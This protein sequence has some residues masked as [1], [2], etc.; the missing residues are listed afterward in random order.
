MN[1]W[2]EGVLDKA[3]SENDGC[4]C[5][6]G[7]GQEEMEQCFGAQNVNKDSDESWKT[8]SAGAN[9]GYRADS[10]HLEVLPGC[11][12]IQNGPA[13]ATPASGAGCTAAP[14]APASGNNSKASSAAASQ[15]PAASASSAAD[16]KTTAKASA[17]V[18]PEAVSS[19]PE[20]TAPSSLYPSYAAGLPNKGIEKETGDYDA[21]KPT[22]A[23]PSG[24]GYPTGP[25]VP[26]GQ[27]P[28]PVAPGSDE[29]CKAP[30]TVTYTPTVT[31]TASAANVADASTCA[32]ET[33]V[34]K[35]L[36]E[37]VT[38]QPSGAKPTSSSS[39]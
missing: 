18:T 26:A 31:V 35:T 27:T 21:A 1:G 29:D 34:Y 33:T 37:T 7:C 6:C 17:T 20:S 16:Y 12:P 5:G 15:T 19:A 11:N 28:S 22:P 2:E 3:V 4:K 13:S 14:S 30:V 25:A 39:Y 32:V 9:S 36:T 24:N 38:V 10:T 23:S 8:C